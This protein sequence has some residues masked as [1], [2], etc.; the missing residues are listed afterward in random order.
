MLESLAALILTKALGWL[1]DGL[2][3]KNFDVSLWRGEVVLNNLKVKGDALDSLGLP[4]AVKSGLLRS[5]RL[6]IPWRSL[7]SEQVVIEISGLDILA[8]PQNEFPQDD[9]EEQKKAA[10][11][12]RRAA[13][14]SKEKQR[15]ERNDASK[16]GVEAGAPPG[17]I[18]A[19]ITSIVDN[20]RVEISD[21]H[22]RIEDH[23]SS[24]IPFVF[25][26]KLGSICLDSVNKLFEVTKDVTNKTRDVGIIRK[27]LNMNDL[28]MYLDTLP[29]SPQSVSSSQRQHVHILPPCS[30]NLKVTFDDTMVGG[31]GPKIED[32]STPV[33][34]IQLGLPSLGLTLSKQQYCSIINLTSFVS[35][36]TLR[37]ENHQHRPRESVMEN[38]KAWW[39][40]AIHSIRD[41]VHKR[42]ERTSWKT[43]LNTA[44]MHKRYVRMWKLTDS[45]YAKKMKRKHVNPEKI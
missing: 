16:K 5:L 32:A 9:Q 43:M 44:M 6:K 15:Q 27:L 22:V 21:I 33:L 4:I 10:L 42:L 20:C 40:Y 7:S 29:S 24:D 36:F 14:V 31:N 18:A 1:V 8:I 23:S 34:G 41:D 28:A 37:F 30:L 2:D 19:L 26:M 45:E 17:R 12:K 3:S 39:R 25:G 13:I 38:P 11:E 35:N